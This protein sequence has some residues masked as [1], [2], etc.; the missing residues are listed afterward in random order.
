MKTSLI[1]ETENFDT[2]VLAFFGFLIYS[3]QQVDLLFLLCS[4][5]HI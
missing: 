5:R 4:S 3:L 1:N 2:F